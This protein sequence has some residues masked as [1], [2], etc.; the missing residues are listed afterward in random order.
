MAKFAIV[1]DGDGLVLNVVIAEAS[2]QPPEGTSKRRVTSRAVSR[3]DTRLASGAYR[4]PPAVA[5][6]RPAAERG[7]EYSGVQVPWTEP[8]CVRVAEVQAIVDA[9]LLVDSKKLVIE[10]S[11]GSR[12]E[13]ADAD[14]S[15]LV[16]A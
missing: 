3:G 14:G 8:D 12:V 13:F 15:F 11:N 9:G 4:P 16:D 10:F 7:F 6:T 2:W 5:D 1:R